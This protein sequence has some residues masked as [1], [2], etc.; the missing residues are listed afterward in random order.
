MKSET[1]MKTSPGPEAPLF[2]LRPNIAVAII[3]VILGS[4]ITGLVFGSIAGTF[5]RSLI[6]GL[7]TGSALILIFLFLRLMNL[8]ARRYVFYKSKAE[9]YEGFLNIIQRTVQYSKITDCVL[10][11]SIWDRMFGTGTIR[12][13]TAGN[14]AGYHGASASVAGSGIILQYLNNPD[15]IYQKL[16]K[17]MG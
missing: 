14:I 4:I 1:N 16:Q 2:V 8:N 13:I 3:P 17:M 5:S 11:K 6:V 7:V 12:M 10:T 9:F 15:Q